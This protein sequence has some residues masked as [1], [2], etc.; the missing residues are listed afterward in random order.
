MNLSTMAFRVFAPFLAL[1]LCIGI[2]GMHSEAV[3]KSKPCTFPCVD[4]ANLQ[5]SI[6][7]EASLEEFSCFMKKWG[8]SETLHFKISIKNVSDKPQRFRVNIFLE[9]GKAVGGW[10]PRKIKKGLVQPGQTGDFVYPV[11]GM[12]SKP[13]GIILK[14]S[15]P[16]P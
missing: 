6:V 12:P 15:I 11:A 8:G 16:R 4:E 10:I 2:P 3:A 13:K 5:K 9:N 7:P 14:I 1:V